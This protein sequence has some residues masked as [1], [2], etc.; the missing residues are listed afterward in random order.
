MGPAGPPPNA[1]AAALVAANAAPAEVEVW[2]ENWPA[3]CLYLR[4]VT[5]WRFSFSGPTGLD[6]GAVYPLIDRMG[7]SPEDW[8]QMLFDLQ[9]IEV[10]ARDQMREQDS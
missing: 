7:L 10:A 3:W 2:P 5:Q 8:D 1:F 9:A 6:Y 4:V